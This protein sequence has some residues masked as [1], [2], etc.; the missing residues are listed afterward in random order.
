MRLIAGKIHDY[1]DSLLKYNSTEGN[2]FHRTNESICLDYNRIWRPF[3]GYKNS[4][5]TEIAHPLTHLLE[6]KYLSFIDHYS[7]R[8]EHNRP[9]VLNF[10]SILFCGKMYFGL[11]CKIYPRGE[12]KSIDTIVYSYGDLIKFCQANDIELQKTS[13]EEQRN[14]WKK[15]FFRADKLEDF[16]TPIDYLNFSIENKLVIAVIDSSKR[17]DY[18]KQ[19]IQLNCSL[20]EYEFYKVFDAYSAYQELSMFV[21]GQLAYPGNIVIEI[22]DK[23]KIESKG[24]DK[25]WSFRKRP[26]KN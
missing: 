5:N 19:Q 22:D 12:M 21:D 26:S 6:E 23:Y 8:T 17:P 18:G 11:R 2:T 15:P 25:K 14:H 10:I 3:A 1:Y 9:F 24:F 7:H 20:K 16:F 4:I 13:K